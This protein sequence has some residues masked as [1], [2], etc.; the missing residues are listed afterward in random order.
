MP[1]ASLET[2]T[3]TQSNG[4]AACT[5]F[6]ERCKPS[7]PFTASRSVLVDKTVTY[8]RLPARLCWTCL[9]DAD[10]AETAL[11][12][13]GSEERTTVADAIAARSAWRAC[14]EGGRNRTERVKTVDVT[15]PSCS[16]PHS[17][18]HT[19]QPNHTRARARARA[20][21]DITYM[22]SMR[23]RPQNSGLVDHGLTRKSPACT[24]P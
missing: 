11:L 15:T 20:C 10:A 24:R 17:L 22:H 23:V 1:N 5:R 13:I 19:P 16:P 12:R 8:V 3:H 9:A 7:T 2:F 4:C 14:G 6:S 18:P 21:A